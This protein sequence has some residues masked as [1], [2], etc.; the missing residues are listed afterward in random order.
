[1][2]EKAA[3]ERREELIGFSRKLCR[4]Q[5]KRG[6]ARRV[7]DLSQVRINERTRRV[8][9]PGRVGGWLREEKFTPEMR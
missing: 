8:L 5:E 2:E 9:K 6:G 3:P 7:T 1:M 4:P